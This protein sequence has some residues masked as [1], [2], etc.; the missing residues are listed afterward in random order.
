MS[1]FKKIIGRKRLIIIIIISLLLS[2]IAIAAGVVIIP[3]SKNST[4]P[5]E[6]VKMDINPPVPA[7]D[8]EEN[9]LEKTIP[10]YLSVFIL[11]EKGQKYTYVLRSTE[12]E[13]TNI[14][15]L[16]THKMENERCYGIRYIF[17]LSQGEYVLFLRNEATPTD[18]GVATLKEKFF[19]SQGE[20]KELNYKIVRGGIE[21]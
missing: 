19:L 5:P 8:A 2:G 17:K 6:V 15:P 21:G 18:N 7:E 12:D 3:A 14:T 13:I 16:E 10:A 9:K 1:I 11:C 4:T 20:M